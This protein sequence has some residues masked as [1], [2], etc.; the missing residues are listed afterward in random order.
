MIVTW[1]NQRGR[2][3]LSKC[4]L[5]FDTTRH[6]SRFRYLWVQRAAPGVIPVCRRKCR[7]KW[8]WSDLV[9]AFNAPPQ[10]EFMRRHTYW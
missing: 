2:V 5:L 6:D 4:R 1:F 7:A 9:G 10:Y 3:W 8:L